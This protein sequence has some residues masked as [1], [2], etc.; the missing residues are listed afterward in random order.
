MN[1]SLQELLS[2]VGIK[3]VIWIDDLF[4]KGAAVSTAQDEIEIASTFAKFK[5]M[6]LKPSHPALDGINVDDELEVWL[7][8]YESAIAESS[9][10]RAEIL[11]SLSAQL[12]E[13]EAEEALPPEDD[14]GDGPL[15]EIVASLGNSVEPYGLT[16][17]TQKQS[18]IKAALD[19]T[20]LVLIDREFKIGAESDQAGERILQEL[21]LEAS[22]GCSLVMLTHSVSQREAE[23]LR[24]TLSR[25]A[26]IPIHRFAVMSKRT[27]EEASLTAVDNLRRSLR[28][29]LVHKT[30]FSMAEKI[31]QSMKRAVEQ[32]VKDLS[33]QSVYD[34]DHSV[35]Q[36]S[37]DEGASET[38]V[39]A[40]IL[41]LRQ[42]VTVDEQIAK[43][44]FLIEQL[45]GLR[46]LRELD[47]LPVQE[48]RPS[49][50][51]LLSAWRNDEVFDSRDRINFSHSPLAC[52]DV[53]GKP[54][55]NA[56]YVLLGPPCDLAVRKDGTRNLDEA[57][58]VLAK[59]VS[60]SAEASSKEMNPQRFFKVPSILGEGEWRLDFL[61][62][63]SVSLRCLELVVFNQSG[64]MSFAASLQPPKILLPGWQKR[65]EETKQLVSLASATQS[66]K[67]MERLSL[68]GKVKNAAGKCPGNGQWRFEYSR[69]GRLRNP[70]AIAAYGAFTSYQTRSAFEHNFAKGLTSGLTGQ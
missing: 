48:A 30:C 53:F 7:E 2:I 31:A 18:A 51:P 45:I 69:V 13:K 68:S 10:A 4:E 58:L 33:D 28:H 70:W 47:S 11:G 66:P 49:V 14:Y 38:G 42:R 46:K 34:L 19:G 20:T 29:L 24:E 55:S 65:F 52:G 21:A 6:E 17:W 25:S 61:E 64:E 44:T 26:N 41:L 57:F 5:A 63:G 56:V 37:L 1:I 35:F 23:Q 59:R 39:L 67:G 50:K 60:Q 27:D 54:D 43:D 3:R 62:W 32:A 8:A 16:D 40:R 12:R 22:L 15:G 36:N 9:S